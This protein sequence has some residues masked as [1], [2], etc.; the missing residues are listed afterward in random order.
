MDNN[1]ITYD[2]KEYKIVEPTI[3]TWQKLMSI[4][5]WTDERE[6]NITLISALSGLAVEDVEKCSWEDVVEASEL[7]SNIILKEGKRFYKDIEFEGQVYSFIDLNNLSF[8]EFIDIDTFLQKP[9]HEKKKEM[10]LLMAMFYRESQN[11]KVEQYDSS[12]IGPRAEKFKK[13]PVKYVNGASTFFLRLEKIL[14]GNIPTSFVS[15]MKLWMKAIGILMILPI[16]AIFGAGS[17]LWS[18]FLTKISPKSRRLQ[19]IP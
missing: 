9:E 6:F 8:G 17:I 12:K 5:D 13:L 3:E 19:S 18:N 4:K 2:G 7:L 16:L 14:Q 11:G 15:K 10:N 1:T